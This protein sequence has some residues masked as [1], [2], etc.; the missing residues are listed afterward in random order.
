MG[1]QISSI[2]V[3]FQTPFQT[4]VTPVPNVFQ[5]VPERIRLR[6]FHTLLNVSYPFQTRFKHRF[7]PCFK[8]F[9]HERKHKKQNISKGV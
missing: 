4:K 2:P 1:V 3:L 6:A 5:T 9:E 7:K 8:P